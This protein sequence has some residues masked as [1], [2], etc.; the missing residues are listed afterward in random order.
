MSNS[1][2][3]KRPWFSEVCKGCLVILV[4]KTLVLKISK[5]EKSKLSHYRDTGYFH[6]F[7]IS[8]AHNIQNRGWLWGKVDS[9]K[10]HRKA[11]V[12][13]RQKCEEIKKI[14]LSICK[15]SSLLQI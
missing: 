6:C 8:L 4:I 14:E 12:Y 5:L 7:L 3:S 11:I 1:G 15:R 2:F 10:R 13:N 9:M